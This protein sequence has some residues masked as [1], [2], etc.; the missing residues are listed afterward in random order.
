MSKALISLKKTSLNPI[1]L[2][3]FKT[4]SAVCL[5]SN[6]GASGMWSKYR[7]SVPP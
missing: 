4:S 7:L 6:S 2:S 1:E 3:P 5:N